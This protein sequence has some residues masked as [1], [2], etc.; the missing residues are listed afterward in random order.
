MSFV[1][2]PF[3]GCDLSERPT[4]SSAIASLQALFA[5]HLPRSNQP[6][7]PCHPR[8]PRLLSLVCCLQRRKIELLHLHQLVHHPFQ[9]GGILDPFG[10]KLRWHH[11]PGKTVLIRE[12]AA[13]HLFPTVGGQLF[14]VIIDLVLC[15]AVDHE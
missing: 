10:E 7:H 15:L 6:S 14:P 9:S 8:N 4:R 5:S 2:P 11:L 12:P 1:P 3:P 13:L